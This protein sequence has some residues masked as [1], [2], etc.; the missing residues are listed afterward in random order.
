MIFLAIQLLISIAIVYTIGY[1]SFKDIIIIMVLSSISNNLGYIEGAMKYYK[2][3]LQDS[4][5]DYVG[6]QYKKKS[7]EKSP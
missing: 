7:E 6:G 3:G 1:V 5:A 2:K 4:K